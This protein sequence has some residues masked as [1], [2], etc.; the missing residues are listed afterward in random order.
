VTSDDAAPPTVG[1]GT[2]DYATAR[3]TWDDDMYAILGLEP[4]AGDAAE[5]AFA[6]MH[7]D[8]VE[9]MTRVMVEAVESAGPF[10]GQYRIRDGRGR[11][12]SI[13]FVGDS[14]RDDDGNPVR[15]VGRGFD[16]TEDV[17]RSETAAVD[18]ATRDRAAIEQLKGALMWSHGL[19]ADTAFGVLSKWSQRGNVRLGTLAR[20]AVDSMA[21]PTHPGTRRASLI[22]VLDAAVAAEGGVTVLP[23]HGRSA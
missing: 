1:T 19:D 21:D 15:L 12:R 10:A 14:V 2:Y 16:V 20:R 18:A 6:R 3:W 23:R 4:G 8:D 13:A 9:R 17:R 5:M 7:P 11:E 22:D